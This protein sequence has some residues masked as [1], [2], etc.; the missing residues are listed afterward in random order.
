M[1]TTA[2]I[3][4]LMVLHVEDDDTTAHVFKLSLKEYEPDVEVFRL[5]DGE[6]VV[7]YLTRS[8]RFFDATRPDLVVLD[9]NLPKKDGH[10]IL[11][12]IRRDAEFAGLPIIVFSSSLD[13]RD[14]ERALL[15]GA[16]DYLSKPDDLD[17]FRA[18][19]AQVIRHLFAT[20]R[21]VSRTLPEKISA[22]DQRR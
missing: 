5:S 11:E 14:R 8:G 16:N 3:A 15:S 9:L 1:E 13:P 4:C 7:P 22:A 2:K 12:E 18:A 10:E 17:G 6:H 20:V 21:S 19:A